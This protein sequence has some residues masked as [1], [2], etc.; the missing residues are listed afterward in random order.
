MSI[1][2]HRVIKVEYAEGPSFNL[3]SDQKLLEFLENENDRGFWLQL[4]NTGNGQV[5][6]SVEVLEKAIAQAEALGL[7]AD[8]V[9]AIQ[10]DIAFAKSQ[11]DDSVTYDCW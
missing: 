4:G 8:G 3:S 5:S 10:A 11:D 2:A 7:D 6:I 1:R 9:N